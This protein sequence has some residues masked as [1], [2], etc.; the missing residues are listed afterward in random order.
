[1]AWVWKEA[2]GKSIIA[3]NRTAHLLHRRDMHIIIENEVSPV[4]CSRAI[5]LLE[6]DRS[7]F[8]E[9]IVAL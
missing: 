5:N 8:Q 9:C 2:V 4:R 3:E 1:M 7:I 6:G